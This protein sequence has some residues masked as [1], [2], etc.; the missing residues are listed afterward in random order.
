MT[1]MRH[2]AS[3][4]LC[5]ARAGID[6]PRLAC[7]RAWRGVIDSSAEAVSAPR[8]GFHLDED[9][10]AAALSNNVELAKGG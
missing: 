8:R 7:V 3:P 4:G 10:D 2:S 9:Q 6:K 1:S 5:H